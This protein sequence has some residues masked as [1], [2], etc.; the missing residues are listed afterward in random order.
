MEVWPRRR[1][2]WAIL[3]A[4]GAGAAACNLLTGVSGLDE[5]P[6]LGGDAADAG[7]DTQL[8]M[9]ATKS[10]A[11]LGDARV[12]L[13][14]AAP[15][16]ADAPISMRSNFCA[17]LDPSPTFCADFDESSVDAGWSGVSL[18]GGTVTLDTTSY[19]SPKASMRAS[20]SPST[21]SYGYAAL[22][23][24]FSAPIGASR[25]TF[26]LE[27]VTIDTCGEYAKF[28]ALTL[29]NA[30]DPPFALF[31]QL[32]SDDGGLILV[33]QDPVDG[34]AN[35]PGYTITNSI[36]TGK[37]THFEIDTLAAPGDGGIG[38]YQVSIDDASALAP[39]AP[40]SPWAYG[41]P[42]INVGVTGVNGPMGACVVRFDNVTFDM[43]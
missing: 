31:L 28:L 9:D 40:Q 42:Q 5:S 20:M 10:D 38:Q 34:G 22:V 21:S 15:D 33:E 41:V 24:N 35:Y 43:E 6:G 25:L 3:A 19:V 13:D 18:N 26:D 16:V 7:N 27:L 23:E 11:S 4:F 14:H 39:V 30:E 29:D 2:S 32:A 8:R 1:R 36:E 17:L 37:W 12:P